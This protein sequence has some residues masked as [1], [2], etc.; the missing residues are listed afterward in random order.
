MKC[1]EKGGSQRVESRNS[2]ITKQL[3]PKVEL[4]KKGKG[5]V[6]LQARARKTSDQIALGKNREEV[7]ASKTRIEKIN[8]GETGIA[9]LSRDQKACSG[10]R[11]AT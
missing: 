1:H 6:E 8:S 10:A 3:D 11:K 7:V 9:G 4:K 2:F 5:A